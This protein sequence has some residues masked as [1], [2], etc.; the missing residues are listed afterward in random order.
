MKSWRIIL[1]IYLVLCGLYWIVPAISFPAQGIIMG[2][3]AIITA[4]LLLMDR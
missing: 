1:G 2:I 4:V 3:L